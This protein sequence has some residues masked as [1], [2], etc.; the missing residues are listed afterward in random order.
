MKN[1]SLKIT[2]NPRKL[3]AKL[4]FKGIDP[5]VLNNIYIALSSISSDVQITPATIELPWH[6]L[7]FGFNNL[8]YHLKNENLSINFDELSQKLINEVVD[9]K[10]AFSSQVKDIEIIESYEETLNRNGFLRKLTN[11]QQRDL[12]KLI[13]LKHGANFSVPG[14]GKTTTLLAVHTIL[15]TLGRVNLLMIVAPINAFL[16]WDNELQEI[17]NNPN[18]TIRRLTTREV[19]DRINISKNN[20]EL[21][22]VNYEK[23]RGEING[24]IPLFLQND[25][26]FVLDESHRIKSGESNISFNQIIRLADL[27]KRRD[28]LSGTPMPQSYLDLQPQFDFLWRRNVFS[29]I[30]QAH[31]SED[32]VKNINKSIFDKYVRTTKD[33]LGLKEPKI[34]YSFV[35]MGPIQSELYKLFKSELARVF[36]GMDTHNKQYFRSIG[37]NVVRLI[38]AVTNPM[39]LGVENEYYQ[40]TVDI[41]KDSNIWELL[42]D[43]SRYEKPVKIEYLLNRVHKLLSED[44]DR[45]IVIWTYFIRNIL[46]LERL[47]KDYS[48]VSIFGAIPVGDS[49]DISFREA[50]II[51]FHEDKNCRILIANPQ[52][53]GEG[54]SLHKA[55]HYAIYLDRNF[56]SA[57]Y[58]QSVDRIH[59]LGLSNAIDTHIEIIMARNSID[60]ILASRLNMKVENMG[61]VLNDP[62]L[63][64]LAYDPEDIPK[65]EM[66]GLDKGDLLEIEKHVMNK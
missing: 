3:I 20:D 23:L 53:C 51:K 46:L 26:H 41:P 38:E 40:N 9:D 39:L 22:I 57:Y 28:I 4:E 37:N 59:R 30:E 44:S 54:I 49:N 42:N 52:A 48:P 24:L 11:E 43:F 27:S 63:L 8:A 29:N 16:A 33:E 62:Y 13:K 5:R 6:D 47:L 50:R 18:L 19:R 35:D 31:F 65:D 7:R 66:F 25:V 17:Y 36:A 2:I 10:K 60:D 1:N 34:Q 32:D 61:K 56:N 14:A 55:S 15:K 12:G 21:L 64:K 58:L 45:K